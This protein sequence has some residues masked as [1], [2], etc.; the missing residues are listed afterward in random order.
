MRGAARAIRKGK[1]ARADG[2]EKKGK[3]ERKR[4][5]K[6]ERGGSSLEASCSPPEGGNAFPPFLHSLPH[7]RYLTILPYHLV[8]LRYP[9]SFTTTRYLNSRLLTRVQL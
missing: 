4:E 5:M 7:V 6:V 2:N 9:V 1:K 3:R 8:S